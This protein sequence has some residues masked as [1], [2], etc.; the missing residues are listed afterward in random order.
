MNLVQTAAETLLFYHPGVW[1]I[2]RQIRLERENCSDDAAVR[3]CGSST[4]LA[5]ALT[6]IE[7]SRLSVEPVLA[8][9]GNRLGSTL[10]RVRRLLDR[11]A[12]PAGP[13]RATAAVVTL[14]LLGVV[15]TTGF[16]T[17][18]T[19]NSSPETLK[20]EPA[21]DADPGDREAV[22]EEET[23][24]GTVQKRIE[25]LLEVLGVVKVAFPVSRP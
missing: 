19:A 13:S 10:R 17:L 20:A 8:A 11:K 23:S 25:E 1:W 15:L 9:T 4:V 14:A 21:V 12:A 24:E 3:V 18:A 22:T 6:E 16:V 7:A 5:E 2:S